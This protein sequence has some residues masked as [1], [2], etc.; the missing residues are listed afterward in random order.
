M[1]LKIVCCYPAHDVVFVA[2]AGAGGK[3]NVAATCRGGRRWR[4]SFRTTTYIAHARTT[5][6]SMGDD[7]LEISLEY[8]PNRAIRLV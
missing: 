2:G 3:G 1:R 5:A 4:S 7:S 6:I 8:M